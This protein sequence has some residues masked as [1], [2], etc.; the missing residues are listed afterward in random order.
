MATV[1][2]PDFQHADLTDAILGAYFAVYNALGTGYLE[3]VYRRAMAMELRARGMP[4]AL[5]V[6]FPVHYRGECVGQYRA[7]IVVARTV[8]VECKAADQLSKAH[9]AQLLNYLKA[10]ALPVG[11]VLNFGPRT[12]IRR[13]HTGPRPRP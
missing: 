2:S 6:P 9:D 1:T 13:I 12:G 11:L 7:D 8:I 3:A 10:S 5:E 4:L